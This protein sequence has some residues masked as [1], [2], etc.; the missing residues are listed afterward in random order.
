V[1]APAA[2]QVSVVIPVYDEKQN[3]HELFQ[4]LIGA[5]DAF[6]RCY[7]LIFTDDGSRDGSLDLLLALRAQ[8]PEQVVVVEFSRNFGQHMA[9]LAGLREARGEIVVTLDADLQNPPEEIPRLV[10]AAEGGHDVVG[11]YRELRHD[12]AFRRIA[13][14]LANGLRRRLTVL[15]MRDH[16]CMLRAYRRE[17]VDA[18]LSSRETSTFIPALAMLYAAR[19][20]ELEVAHAARSAGRS[21]YGLYRLIRLNFDLM[22]GF[23]AAPLQAF[24]LIGLAVSLLSAAMVVVLAVRRVVVGPE[25]EGIFTL[26]GILFFLLGVAITGLGIIGEYVAR[27]YHEVRR[28]PPYVVRRVHGRSSDG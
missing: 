13:S 2:P 3:L 16:G 26:M 25:V 8:R 14:W 20:I 15:P 1:S 9:V 12:N 28:R 4:R 17:V 23:S 11:T 5:L 18:V 27:I 21:K 22:T 19:P 7:E 6:G 10:L 24:T